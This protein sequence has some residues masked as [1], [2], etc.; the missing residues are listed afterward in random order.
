MAGL[1][2]GSRRG[3]PTDLLEAFNATGLT[4][5]I[6]ISG[7]N[8]TIVIAIISSMLFWLPFKIRFFP[9]VTA[10]VAFTIFVG[11][12]AA[13]I[14]AAIMG[15]L[16]L[17]ALKNGRTTTVRISILWTAFFMIAWNPKVLWYDAGFQLSFL[18][19]IGLTELGTLLDTVFARVPKTLAIRESLQMTVAAQIAAVP[20]IIILFRR[21]SLIAPL[22]NLLI[23]PVIPLAM[24]FG[25]LGTVI[26][27]GLFPLG[28]LFSYLGWACLTWIILIANICSSIPY[29][30]LELNLPTWTLV[31]YY[32]TIVMFVHW[33]NTKLIVNS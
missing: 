21:C 6:A 12:S 19:V 1:L 9:A 23:A 27:F 25:S 4:H 15:I 14:R 3:I 10:I 5:I 8:I 7:Y 17:I 26:S 30:S 32:G 20:L 2:T 24:L 29:A 16:G 33:K 11:A 13:V 22:A 18:A 28:Q 31:F